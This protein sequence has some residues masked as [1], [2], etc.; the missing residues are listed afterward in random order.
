MRREVQFLT[1]RILCCKFLKELVLY[2][3]TGLLQTLALLVLTDVRTAIGLR[4]LC[5]QCA[6]CTNGSWILKDPSR[7]S[8]MGLLSSSHC[9]QRYV[10]VQCIRTMYALMYYPVPMVPSTYGTQYL[11]VEVPEPLIKDMT[12][13]R[14]PCHEVVH[15]TG[16]EAIL[17]P[18]RTMT[19]N[20]TALQE[21]YRSCI[22][23]FQGI[24]RDVPNPTGVHK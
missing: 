7:T 2:N 5:K 1:E 15:W 21:I 14:W 23:S 6:I 12:G 22:D 13:T 18:C 3:E 11:W 20:S 19:M 10:Q 24:S 16:L 9:Q 4:R 8:T 17:L